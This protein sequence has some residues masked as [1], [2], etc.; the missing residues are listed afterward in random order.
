MQLWALALLT[1]AAAPAAA[2]PPQGSVGIS[3]GASVEGD[4][5]WS[6][7][8]GLRGDL[9]WGRNTTEDVGFGVAARVDTPAFRSFRAGLGPEFIAP[10]GGGAQGVVVVGPFLSGDSLGA[11]AR[12][13]LSAKSPN[14]HGSYGMHSGVFCELSGTGSGLASTALVA[15]IELDLGLLA[16]PVFAALRPLGGH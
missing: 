12:L 3:V 8:P 4:F 10:L 1:L 7:A 9:S 2:A 13:S 15:G 11:F 16:L 5:G 14:Q 6:V